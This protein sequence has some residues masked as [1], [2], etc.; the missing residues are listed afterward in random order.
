MSSRDAILAKVRAGVAAGGEV[1]PG[2]AAERANSVGQRLAAE[3][4]NLIPA[5]AQNKTV[6]ERVAILRHWVELAGGDVVE[7][8]D[9]TGL[10]GAVAAYLTAH[11]AP[12]TVRIG[13]D[14]YLEGVAWGGAAN[15]HVD[16]GASAPHDT[17]SVTRAL[18]AV[19][20]TGT[21]VVA[22]GPGN[23][24]TLSFL[25]ETNIVVVR[26]GDVVGPLEDAIAMVR[27]TGAGLPRTLNMISGPSRSA[28]IGGVPVLGA[29]GPKRMCV[30]VVDE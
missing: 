7:I 2:H 26:R 16:F 12:L 29:H 28:D 25:P 5:R 21:V 6:D 10:A 1:P 18:A 23:P 30:V 13:S 20:E 9:R 24:V 3:S 19:A 22:S 8:A 11:K 14:P 4:R 27:A 15:L 17:A